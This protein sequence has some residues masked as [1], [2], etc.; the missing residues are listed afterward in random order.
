[1]LYLRSWK[2]TFTFFSRSFIV[3]TLTFTCL[4]H[5]KLVFVYGVRYVSNQPHSFACEFPVVPA[6]LVEKFVLF[7]LNCVDTLVKNQLTRNVNDCFWT[8]PVHLASNAI[9]KPKRLQ[10]KK[11]NPENGNSPYEYSTTGQL[12]LPW[13]PGVFGG[14]SLDKHQLMGLDIW[15]SPIV[16]YEPN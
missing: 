4:I 16:S 11:L 5:F 15:M 10:T 3:L 14:I 1:M 2:Y 13:L 8:L 9:D 6:P 7:L 12:R